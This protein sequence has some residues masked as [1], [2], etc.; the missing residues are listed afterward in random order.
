MRTLRD[1]VERR[2]VLEYGLKYAYVYITNADGRLLDEEAFTQPY[3]LERNECHVEA[4]EMYDRI[5][6]HLN[7]TI[8]FPTTGGGGS[9]DRPN[10]EED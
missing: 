2:I 10:D 3:R 8:N 9:S 1:Y 4:K 6:E 5:W 7:E